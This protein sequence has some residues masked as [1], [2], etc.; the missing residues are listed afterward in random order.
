MLFSLIVEADIAAIAD[1][2]APIF[3]LAGDFVQSDFYPD[4]VFVDACYLLLL[5]V[6]APA[7]LG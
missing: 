4:A 5:G 7:F 1:V 3:L 6:Y 2:I